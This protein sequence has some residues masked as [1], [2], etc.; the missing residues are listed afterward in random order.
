MS[1]RIVVLA[2]ITGFLRAQSALIGP[3][4]GFVFDP[5]T[6][7]IRAVNGVLGSATL[8]RALSRDL[9][10]ASIAPHASFGIG[11]RRGECLLISGLDSGQPTAA[12]I[13]ACPSLPEGVAWSGDGSAAALYSR[14]GNWIQSLTG[15]PFAPA[16]GAPVSLSPLGGALAAVAA[17]KS[18]LAFGMDSGSV[19]WMIPGQS[20]VP[21]ASQ[22]QA[23]AL[24]FSDDES[25][26]YVL[27]ASNRCVVEIDLATSASRIYA[28]DMLQDPIALQPVG[29]APHSLYVLGRADRLL[30]TLD[31]PSHQV[32]ASVALNFDPAGFER[33]GKGSA[34][35]KPRARSRDPLWAV[36][37][38]PLLSVYFI[39][40]ATSSGEEGRR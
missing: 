35:L 13:S 23:R 29:G 7:T 9:D 10:F 3:V 2:L 25:A 22:V 18:H 34:V 28:V 16:A 1:Q 32:T 19:Y 15:L 21:L 5:P 4:E 40:A 11:F 14:T 24:V 12:A 38:T 26:L 36:T 8:G 33:L 39:P 17:A 37:T 27:D 6:R 20:F 31:G 30:V